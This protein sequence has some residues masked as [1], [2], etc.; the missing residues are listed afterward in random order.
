MSSARVPSIYMRFG[1]IFCLGIFQCRITGRI[2]FSRSNDITF[3][4]RILYKYIYK[5]KI[6]SLF[7][8][9]LRCAIMTLKISYIELYTRG[10]TKYYKIRFFMQIHIIRN[11]LY[12]S[13]SFCRKFMR[14]QKIKGIFSL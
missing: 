10:E 6:L 3:V 5:K 8:L 11:I 4:P 9:A 7:Y 14:Y 12:L 13:I 2:S 1:I